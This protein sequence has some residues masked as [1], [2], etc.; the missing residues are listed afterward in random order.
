MTSA[1]LSRVGLD[2]ALPREAE[3]FDMP[4]VARQMWRPML[5]MGLM[6]VAAGVVTG[7]VQA[8]LDR[9]LHVAQITAWNPGLLFLGI[10]L[11]L[12]SVTFLLATILGEL[13]D[14]GTTVQKA[15]G[16]HALILKRPL[17][18]KA[19]P[20]RDDDGADDAARRA[21]G[22][23]RGGGAARHEPLQCGRHRRLGGA[24]PL[25]GRRAPL[26][27]RVARTRDDRPLAPLPGEPHP[28]DSRPAHRVAALART[29]PTAASPARR[30]SLVGAM[31]CY[32]A[33]A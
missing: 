9:P 32:A 12:G 14:G 3:G 26:H 33:R 8:T 21:C 23:L 28:A 27:R 30:P 25:L 1:T 24:A 17:T 7:I 16:E 11:L 22:G 6:A 20:D 5:A 18:G 31:R 15:L 10:G 2:L 19:L 4:A 29:T 13:R